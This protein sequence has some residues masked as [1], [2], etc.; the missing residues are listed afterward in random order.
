MLFW[1]RTFPDC[2]GSSRREIPKRSHQES[3]CCERCAGATGSLC[4]KRRIALLGAPSNL[5]LKPYEDN[6]EARGVIDTP[7]VLRGEQLVER[8]Q[9]VDLGDVS[10]PAYRDYKRPRGGTR[11]E[12]EIASYS[13]ELAA[14][15]SRASDHFVL[16]LG[17]DCSI[18]LGTLLGFQPCGLVFI[19]GHS[20]FATPQISQSGGAAG[21]DLA[22]AVGRGNSLL[23]RLGQ[24]LIREQEVALLGRKD[25][26]DEPYFGDESVRYSNVLDLPW[27]KMKRLG[28]AA[29][30]QAALERVANIGRGF[31]IHVDADVLDPKIMPAVDSP[32]PGGMRL[33][34]LG[35]LLA[36]LCN[37]PRALALQLTVYDP[38]LDP[39]R[40]CARA[41]VELLVSA[42][43]TDA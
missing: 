29:V 40:R 8:L 37:H 27:K 23:S 34:E 5:G 36:A 31:V 43:K 39:D 28:I 24:P 26:A 38:R 10:A 11:N 30:V 22:L 17:G 6:G 33:E 25:E 12:R 13:K 7:A 4:M 1:A 32:E 3:E 9:A 15:I 35:E 19:D 42:L 20:D 14:A 2:N 18:L 16:L 41:L 21:M